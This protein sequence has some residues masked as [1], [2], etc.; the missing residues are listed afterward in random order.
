VPT[1]APLA[2][3]TVTAGAVNDKDVNDWILENMNYYYLWNDKLPAN[4]N[5]TLTPDKFFLSLLYD[6]NNTANSDRDRFSWLQ[7]SATELK[8]SLSGETKTTGMEFRLFYRDQ[9]QT[10]IIGSVLE[11]KNFEVQFT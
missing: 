7:A 11:F 5:K 3:S 1:S 9:S 2:S 4:P 10:A 8:A 6:R